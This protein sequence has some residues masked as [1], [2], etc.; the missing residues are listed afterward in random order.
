MAPPP[1][2]LSMTPAWPMLSESFCPTM[3]AIRSLPPPGVKPTTIWIARD[4]YF[5]TSSCARTALVIK[6]SSPRQETMAGD[7]RQAFIALKPGDVDM[8]YGGLAVVERGKTSVDGGCELVGFGAAFAVRAERLCHTCEFPPL[9][10]TARREPRLKLVGRSSHTFRVAALHRRLH[11][12]PATIVEHDREDRHAVL[13]RNRIDAVGR[14]EMKPTVADHLHD[15]AA[16]F[17]EFQPERHAAG[18]AEAAAGKPHLA[19]GHGAREDHKQHQRD[20]NGVD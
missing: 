9:A 17:G 3:R 7:F 18:K 2:L 15:A 20:A 16:R 12:L 8:K 11:R 10:L 4:G 14:G 1:G 6:A 13:L 5:A 19:E